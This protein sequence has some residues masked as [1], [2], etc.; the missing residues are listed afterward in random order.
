M[1]AVVRR[2]V[3]FALIAYGI[4]TFQLFWLWHGRP[5]TF[6]PFLRGSFEVA[7]GYAEA[8][9]LPGPVPELIAYLG[10][11]AGAAAILSVAELRAWRSGAAPPLYQ[12]SQ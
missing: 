7:A 5:D 2:R 10:L 6:L 11:A 4:M 1:V 8:M 12:P 9:S 3:P